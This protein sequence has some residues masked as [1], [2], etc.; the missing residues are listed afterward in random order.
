MENIK[1]D[2]DLPNKPVFQQSSI[3]SNQSN[4][5]ENS[6]VPGKVRQQRSQT[7]EDC[8][9]W[10]PDGVAFPHGTKLRGKYKGYVYHGKVNNGAFILNGEEFLSP[11]AAAVTITRN[12][13]DGWLF[14]DCK[15]PDR[16]SWMSI[17][18][19]KNA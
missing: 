6:D 15:L 16:S 9:P 8:I 2:F 18:E 17:Y 14:W 3:K 13:V 4:V 5:I 19:L 1:T 7:L 12:P 10:T 11:C